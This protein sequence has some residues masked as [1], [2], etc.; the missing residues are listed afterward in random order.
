VIKNFT[1]NFE[2]LAMFLYLSNQLWWVHEFRLPTAF[3]RRRS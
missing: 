2:P 1:S 3:L